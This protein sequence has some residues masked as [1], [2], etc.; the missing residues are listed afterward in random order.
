MVV[1]Q[2]IS[3]LCEHYRIE[4]ARV[5]ECTDELQVFRAVRPELGH[6]KI[7]RVEE[8]WVRRLRG[9]KPPADQSAAPAWRQKRRRVDVHSLR[10][11]AVGLRKLRHFADRSF[12]VIGLEAIRV[13]EE[14]NVGLDGRRGCRWK[15]VLIEG[16]QNGLRAE[17][18][19]V[20]VTGDVARGAKQL[21]EV[22][23]SHAA[24]CS[25]S[26]C[27]RKERSAWRRSTS[28]RTPAYGLF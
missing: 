21:G 8:V 18:P 5:E 3:P 27:S 19:D 14:S 28:E 9:T 6:G 7:M 22:G 25:R 26:Q 13:I 1:R 15:V 23:T 24:E 4:H 17:D 16:T 20:A 11:E 10:A 12:D 2:Q